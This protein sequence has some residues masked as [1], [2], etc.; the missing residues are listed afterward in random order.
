MEQMI[1]YRLKRLDQLIEDTFDRVLAAE[2]V[3]RRQWQ[4]LN[5]LRRTPAGD[6]E[7]DAALQPFWKTDTAS[8]AEVVEELTRRGWVARD[9]DGRH[10][11]TPEGRAAHAALA[12]S[13]GGIRETMSRGLTEQEYRTT[14]DVLGRMID[15]LE[16]AAQT[17]AA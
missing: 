10:A 16:A 13:V 12:T 6:A 14:M 3:S 2:G 5:V 17:G 7:L 8:A 11:L 15:N 4:T 9:P 1:G